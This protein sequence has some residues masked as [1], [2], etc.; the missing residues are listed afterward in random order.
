MPRNTDMAM[1]RRRGRYIIFGI[2]RRCKRLLEL[3]IVERRDRGGYG[4]GGGHAR[5][6][7]GGTS[8]AVASG[9][10]RSWYPAYVSMNSPLNLFYGFGR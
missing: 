2:Q 4:R 6:R 10:R 9:L 1:R 8:D 3:C 7:R 5:G